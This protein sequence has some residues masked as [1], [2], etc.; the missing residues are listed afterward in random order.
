MVWVQRFF[1]DLLGAHLDGVRAIRGLPLLFVLLVGWEFAQHVM[2]VRVGFFDSW[3]AKAF[4]PSAPS[5]TV[6]GRSSR[7]SPEPAHST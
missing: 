5:I 1:S 4:A 7:W 3:S 6:Q 2:E